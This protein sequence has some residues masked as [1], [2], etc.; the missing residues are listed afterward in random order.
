[1]TDPKAGEEGKGSDNMMEVEET[2]PLAK[3]L[4][5]HAGLLKLAMSQ[6]DKQLVARVL[7]HLPRFG[8]LLDPISIAEFASKYCSDNLICKFLGQQQSVV[9]KQESGKAVEVYAW[10]LLTYW[11]VKAEKYTEVVQAAEKALELCSAAGHQRTLDPIQAKLYF[12]QSLGHEKLGLLVD[13][14]HKLMVALRT[15]SLRHDSDSNAIIYNW[16]LRSYVLCEQH[17]LASKFLEKSQFPAV[18]SGA[19]SARYHYYLARVEAVQTNYQ[20]ARDH[21]SQ[22]ITKAPHVNASIGLIQSAQKLLVVVQ[23]LLGDI[24]E[25]SLFSQPKMA[26][27]LQPYFA[28]CQAVRLGDLARFQKV[29]TQYHAQF[30]ADRNDSII[31]RLHQNV[32]RAGLKRLNFAYSRIP[33]AEVSRKLGLPSVDDAKFVV[34]KAIKDGVIDAIVDHSQQ[35]MQSNATVNSYYTEEPH[36]QLHH[37]IQT[38]QQIYKQSMMAMK[39]PNGSKPA[40]PGVDLDSLPNEMDL[41]EEYMD[42][43]EMDF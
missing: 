15:T 19:Q 3:Q 21:L 10:L 8:A 38:A 25:R 28:L 37:R 32:L 23:L 6:N 27:P 12:Y 20:A 13:L 40:S 14:R 18:A 29:L 17:D 31:T 42:A 41:M 30:K 11:L 4:E 7:H 36:G 5:V 35:F 16:I 34:M 9:E 26:R 2:V 33:L 24:P 39:Y 22:A 1:M 43:D